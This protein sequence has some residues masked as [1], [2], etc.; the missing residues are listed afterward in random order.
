MERKCWSEC[1]SR[2][3]M[4]RIDS[5]Y[6]HATATDNHSIW[7]IMAKPNV[8]QLESRFRKAGNT[9]TARAQYGGNRA[10]IVHIARRARDNLVASRLIPIHLHHQ[11][12]FWQCFYLH[13]LH[14]VGRHEHWNDT[15]SSNLALRLASNECHLFILLYH[16]PFQRLKQ[17]CSIE[18]NETEDV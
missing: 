17:F 13:G 15:S 8:K 18:T 9:V 10:G 2:D 1:T 4:M 6:E 11:P 7:L 5:S 3:S 12:L 16:C 14:L